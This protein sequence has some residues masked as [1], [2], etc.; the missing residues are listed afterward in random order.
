VANNGQSMAGLS[1][2]TPFY[3]LTTAAAMMVGRFGLA[4]PAL[5]LAGLLAR[6]GRRIETAGSLPCD[7]V[8]FATVVLGSALLI[9]GLNFLPALALG[10]MVEH[11]MMTGSDSLF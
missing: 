3:N 9:G 1:A 4:I 5:A 10:P 6:Q 8:L 7:S 11:L 2:A